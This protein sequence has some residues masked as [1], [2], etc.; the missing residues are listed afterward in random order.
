MLVVAVVPVVAVVQVVAVVLVVAVI[1]CVSMEPP[2]AARRTAR[3][4]VGTR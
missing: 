1:L 2:A 4:S 3:R